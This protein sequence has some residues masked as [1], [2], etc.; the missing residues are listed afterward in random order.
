M[1]DRAERDRLEALQG[2]V[3]ALR[4]ELAGIDVAA[5]R[6]RAADMLEQQVTAERAREAE[7]LM[8]ISRASYERDARNRELQREARE[9]QAGEALARHRADTTTALA[10]QLAHRHPHLGLDQPRPPVGDYGG[11]AGEAERL[12]GSGL[13]TITLLILGVLLA[14]IWKLAGGGE[15]SGFGTI[16]GFLMVGLSIVLPALLGRDSSPSTKG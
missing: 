14:A 11:P 9:R 1:T 16:G 2:R 12:A 4:D 5:V 6:A 7:L 3:R 10:A 8:R 13:A 15:G